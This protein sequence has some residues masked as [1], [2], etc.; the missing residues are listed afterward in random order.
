MTA[1]IVEQ[2]TN[3]DGMVFVLDGQS[4]PIVLHPFRDRHDLVY[5]FQAKTQPTLLYQEQGEVGMN[6]W[7]CVLTRVRMNKKGFNQ[8]V[9]FLW[10]GIYTD[11]SFVV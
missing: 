1:G 7:D 2:Y 10:R 9:S 8:R 3:T 11:L 6:G 4:L 5:S